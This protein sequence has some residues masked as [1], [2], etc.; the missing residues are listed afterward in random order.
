MK[1]GETSV[2]FKRI[3]FGKQKAISATS[4]QKLHPLV[5]CTYTPNSSGKDVKKNGSVSLN[6]L[7][8]GDAP[9]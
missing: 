7:S 2:S 1:F 8:W 5:M 4:E 9:G 6:R 3:I